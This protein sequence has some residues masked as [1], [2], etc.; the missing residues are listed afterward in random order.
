MLPMNK[1]SGGDKIIAKLLQILNQNAVKVLNSLC[2]QIWKTQ[3]WPQ[4]WKRSVF[5]LIPKKSSAKECSN[6]HTMTLISTPGRFWS[7]SFKLGFCSI[8]TENFQTYKLDLEK[9][10]EPEIKLPHLL[11]HRGARKFQKYIYFCFTDYAKAFDGVDHDKLWKIL[12]E[13]GIPDHLTC[14]LLCTFLPM[15]LVTMLLFSRWVG[16][17]SLP[18]HGLQHARLPCPSPS[19]KVCSNSRPSSRWCHPAISCSVTRFSSCPQSL[20]T[21]GS[22]PMSQLLAS[23]GQGIEA[24]A[25]ALVTVRG[26]D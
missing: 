18:P 26:W 15:P 20:P 25:S 22:F 17:N 6:Y 7:E 23:G 9:A 5:I 12:Q 21:S 10:E 1:A 11:D 14:L 19:P 24:S 4:N 16:S 13:T 3:Q 2:Q 8:W